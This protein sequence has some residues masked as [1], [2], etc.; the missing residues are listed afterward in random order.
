MKTA[1][2]GLGFMGGMHVGAHLGTPGVQLAAVCSDDE[3]QLTGDLTAVQG[4]LG[5]QGQRFDFSGV[6][7]YRHIPDLLADPEI[8]AV[9]ICLPTW[10]HEEVAVAAL[11]AGKHVLV[12]K[13]MAL[14]GAGA[15]RMIAAAKESGRILMCAQVLRFFPEYLALRDAIRDLG[16]VRAAT[17]GR[18]CAEPGWGGWLKDPA[19]SGGGVFDLVIHDVDACLWLFGEPGAVAA[20]G[21]G[22]W[23]AGQ[24]FYDGFTVGIE[25]G[26]QDSPVYPFCMEYRVTLDKG[27]VEFSST[28]KPPAVFA[29]AERKL[30]LATAEGYAAEVAYFVECCIAGRAPERCPPEQSARAVEMTRTLLD[31][32]AKNGEKI[33]CGNRE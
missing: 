32:R 15:R 22:N 9:D 1:V 7:P 25:G 11:R 13:P 19:K 21:Y 3:R 28:G 26:W 29:E 20:T 17:F 10:L 16:K 31:A 14:D 2:L 5:G 23:V 33:L 12:E 24:L 27:T 8:D 4:N 6:K 18:R 30:P